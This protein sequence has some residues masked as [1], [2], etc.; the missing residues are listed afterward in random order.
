MN[1]KSKKKTKRKRQSMV[2]YNRSS[3]KLWELLLQKSIEYSTEYKVEVQESVE[4]PWKGSGLKNIDLCIQSLSDDNP[5]MFLVM[6]YADRKST[7]LSDINISNFL[8]SCMG[9]KKTSTFC[10]G[11]SPSCIKRRRRRSRI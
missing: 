2:A 5:G 8:R 11:I 3:S 9:S 10:Y 6:K 1:Q 4:G 7:Q